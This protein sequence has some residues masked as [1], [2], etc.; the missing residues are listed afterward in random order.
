M[1]NIRVGIFFGTILHQNM[2]CNA[3]NYSFIQLCEEIGKQKDWHFQY[4]L[5]WDIPASFNNDNLPRELSGYDISFMKIPE[6]YLR[7]WL[8]GILKDKMHDYNQFYQSIKSCD[9]FVD[10][11]GGDSFS[12]IYGSYTL[13]YIGKNHALANKF[14]KPIILL[15]QTIGPFHT[16]EGE[17]RGDWMMRNA[18]HVF[19]RDSISHKVAQRHISCEK[20]TETIDMAFYMDFTAMSKNVNGTTI[21]VSPSALLWN[22][23]YTGSNQFGLKSDYRKTICRIIEHLQEEECRVVLLAHV[24]YGTAS[25]PREDDYWLCKKLQYQYPKCEL[26]PFF[27]TP[28]EAKGFISSLDGLMSSRMH[29][30]IGAYSSGV[31][32]F[33]LGYSRKFNGLFEETLKYPYGADLREDDM[34]E[35]LK[36]LDKY[37]A[38]LNY[39]KAG[40]PNRL[41]RIKVEKEMFIQRLTTVFQACIKNKFKN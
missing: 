30:C 26:A 28:M 16:K 3:L 32:V 5:Y 20:I 18:T 35:T 9:F 23:G 17:K 36:H 37:L 19:V 10:T 27:Y 39:I 34:E 40:M 38:D 41:Q 21:G 2:G 24:L 14:K 7:L 11:C 22:G 6:S 31:P 12:D 1:R 29:C 15:P 25:Q 13:K 8:K 33:T 4:I